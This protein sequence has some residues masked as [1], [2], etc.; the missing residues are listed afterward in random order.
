VNVTVQHIETYLKHCKNI[1]KIAKSQ[2]VHNSRENVEM[3][4]IKYLNIKDLNNSKDQNSKDQR[5][6]IPKIKKLPRA[7]LQALRSMS[8]T[9]MV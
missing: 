6:K 3:S 1:V 4:V 5:L 2:I 9:Y 8:V 7:T